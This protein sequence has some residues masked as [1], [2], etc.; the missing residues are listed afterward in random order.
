MR[1]LIVALLIAFAFPVSAMCATAPTNNQLTAL[2]QIE[3]KIQVVDE[4]AG[5]HKIT[6]DEAMAADLMFCQDAAQIL[7]HQVTPDQLKVLVAGAP[8]Q[9]GLSLFW[10]I[11]IVIAGV[12]VVIA[13]LGLIG[14][15]LR[16]LLAQIPP[17]IYEFLAYVATAGTIFSGYFLHPFHLGLV[18]VEPLWFVIPGA[19]ALVGCITL[20]NELHFSSSENKRYNVHM[21][22]DLINFPTVLFALC[23]IAWAALALFYYRLFPETGIPHVLAFGAVIA[24]QASLGFSVLTMPGC[25]FLGWENDQQVPKSVFSSFIILAAYVFMKLTHGLNGALALFEPGAIFMGAFVYYLGLLLMSSKWYVWATERNRSSGSNYILLQFLTIV[26]GIAA[27]YFG[28]AFN[29]GALLGVG[30][31]FFALYLLEKYYEIPWKGVGWFW[32]LLGVAGILYA[33]VGFANNNPQYFI[34]GIR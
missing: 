33:L 9:S 17:V 5:R 16:D 26:S 22:P 30:G 1:R 31:T 27:L 18:R 7:G 28:S 20:T 2:E 34:W 32:S 15:Y 12:M 13:V 21:G 11:V 25:V 8:Q 24:L 4:L 29:L 14:F 10:N 6:A 19:L 23:T 3:A